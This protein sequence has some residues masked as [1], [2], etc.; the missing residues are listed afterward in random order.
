MASTIKTATQRLNNDNEGAIVGITVSNDG[1]VE[2]GPLVV[3]AIYQGDP[4]EYIWS[5]NIGT[6]SASSSTM[7]NL[8]I[9]NNNESYSEDKLHVGVG[10]M[11]KYK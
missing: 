2:V 1:T 4:Y 11:N 5:E 10:F 7:F 8:A 3:T 9:N 6:L